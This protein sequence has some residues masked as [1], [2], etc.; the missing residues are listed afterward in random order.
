M[1]TPTPDG[2]LFFIPSMA[3]PVKGKVFG[4]GRPH[5]TTTVLI[6]VDLIVYSDQGRTGPGA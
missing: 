5:R 2:D 4:R 3:G 1:M 6:R